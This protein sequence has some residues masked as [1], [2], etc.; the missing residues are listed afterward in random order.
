MDIE[1]AKKDIV[2]FAENYIG[3][4]LLEWQKEALR[5]HQSG[6]M[7]YLGGF[8]SGKNIVKESIIEWNN[9]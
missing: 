5:K 8:R 4:T 9:L 3:I 1:R 7:I 2:Y 6:E